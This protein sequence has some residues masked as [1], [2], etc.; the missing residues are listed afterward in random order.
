[1][2]VSDLVPKEH[3]SVLCN[4]FQNEADLLNR[5]TV[6]FHFIHL[7]RRKG[8]PTHMHGRSHTHALTHLHTH[9]DGRTHKDTPTHAC[10]HARTHTRTHTH[11]HA[12]ARTH[13][14]GHTDVHTNHLSSDIVIPYRIMLWCNDSCGRIQ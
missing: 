5:L 1:M 10:T 14:H 13:A 2:C 8:A 4:G 7:L 9:V 6:A 3:R 12:R 11:T